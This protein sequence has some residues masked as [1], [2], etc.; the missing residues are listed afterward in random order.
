MMLFLL[1]YS[2]ETATLNN[3]RINCLVGLGRKQLHILT[4]CPRDLGQWDKALKNETI[5]YLLD[6]WPYKMIVDYMFTEVEDC[7]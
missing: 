2:A 7:N 4:D 3:L 5:V 1:T 6:I